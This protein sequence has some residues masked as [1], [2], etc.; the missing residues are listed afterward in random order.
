MTAVTVPVIDTSSTSSPSSV[1][2]VSAAVVVSAADVVVS[3]A[4]VVAVVSFLEEQ[5]AVP[6]TIVKIAAVNN[7]FFIITNH[8]S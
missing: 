8:S 7:A 6:I 5:A 2:S 4:V 3:A 1:S